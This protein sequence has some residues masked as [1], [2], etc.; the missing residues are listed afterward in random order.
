LL[1]DLPV[2]DLNP[3]KFLSGPSTRVPVSG[4]SMFP[5]LEEGDQVE[6]VS[7][8]KGDFSPGDLV[9]FRRG[10]DLIV[11]RL[12]KMR[13]GYFLEMGDNQAIGS[14]EPWQEHT[15][16]VVRILKKSGAVVETSGRQWAK[17]RART[18]RMQRLKHLR[19]SLEKIARYKSLRTMVRLPFR[20]LELVL[21][22]RCLL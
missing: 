10:G 2:K 7:A 21:V 16:K 12:L 20:L 8:G 9:V 14:W 17:E 15:G 1:Q 22:K 19:S 6:V 3:L 5:F 11:H 4:I 18:A 13:R